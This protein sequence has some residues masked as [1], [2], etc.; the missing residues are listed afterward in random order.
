MAL[1]LALMASPPAGEVADSPEA[2]ESRTAPNVAV[3]LV[4]APAYVRGGNGSTSLVSA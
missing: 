3:L 4:D 2:F 1:G